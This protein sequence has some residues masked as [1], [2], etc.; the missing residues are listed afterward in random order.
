MLSFDDSGTFSAEERDFLHSFTV[1]VSQALRRG[2]AYQLEHRTSERLQRSLLPRSLPDLSGSSSARTYRPGGGDSDVGGDWYDVL[3]L[4]DGSVVASLGDVM[5]KGVPAAIVM[6][7]LG[8]APRLRPARPRPGV[9]LPR[10]DRLATTLSTEQLVTLAYAVVE[11]PRDP[12]SSRSPATRRRCCR[13]R[14]SAALR[15]GG[16]GPALGLGVGGRTG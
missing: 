5:G 10:L 6:S 1:Q 9:L 12:R 4:E 7:E 11:P 16:R 14:G 8:R 2:L 13:R 15:R 3:P